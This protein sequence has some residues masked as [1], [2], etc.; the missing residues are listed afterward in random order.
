MPL[1]HDVPQGFNL[2]A[3]FAVAD[4]DDEEEEE[5]EGKAADVLTFIAWVWDFRSDP[6]GWRGKPIF[7][8][9]H[10]PDLFEP[11]LPVVAELTEDTPETVHQ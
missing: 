3:G 7:D 10:F 1:S 6:V 4:Y 2:E 8:P 5:E 11:W 9:T